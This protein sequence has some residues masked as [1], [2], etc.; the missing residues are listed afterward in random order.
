MTATP[1]GAVVVS[2]PTGG[3]QP[4]TVAP[5]TVAAT[6]VPT[7][8]PP[9][10]PTALPA[11]PSPESV[12]A[13]AVQSADE[14]TPTATPPPQVFA[15]ATAQPLLGTPGRTGADPTPVPADQATRNT[16]SIFLLGGGAILLAAAIGGGLLLYFAIAEVVAG[17]DRTCFHEPRQPDAAMAQRGALCPECP[18]LAC[19]GATLGSLPREGI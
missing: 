4:P 7:P 10:E 18:H 16:G 15:A 19:L 6:A 8:L 17:H 2:T 1:I 3:P 12:A 5:L 11:S 13:S 9:V 14:A